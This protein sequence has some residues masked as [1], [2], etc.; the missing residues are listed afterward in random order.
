MELIPSPTSYSRA[1]LLT[2]HRRV[3]TLETLKDTVL[4]AGLQISHY[5]GLSIK[6]LSNS[7]M[8]KLQKDLQHAF[9]ELGTKVPAEIC[10]EL[11]ICCRV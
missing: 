4:R 5:A 8:S 1:D 10:A 9:T 11:F 3:Y 7:Q 2:G 6:P